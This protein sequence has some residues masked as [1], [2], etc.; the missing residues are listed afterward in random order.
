[1]VGEV[2]GEGE[3]VVVEEVVEVEV[4]ARVGE[5]RD[6]EGERVGEEEVVGGEEA[7]VRGPLTPP[8]TPPPLLLLLL[9]LLP[10]IMLIG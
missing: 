9:L 5:V 1:M 8:L 2:E 3:E 10:S 7:G 6:G 4:A